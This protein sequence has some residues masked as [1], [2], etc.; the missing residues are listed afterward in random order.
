MGK[1]TDMNKFRRKLEEGVIDDPKT[2]GD[3]LTIILG[4]D[5][6]GRPLVCIEQ[7]EVEGSHEHKERILI[8]GDMMNSLIEELINVSEIID[9][10]GKV[11]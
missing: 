1:V 2:E 5:K 8:N 7:C 9:S 11:H 10:G 4:E 6:E 3:Y